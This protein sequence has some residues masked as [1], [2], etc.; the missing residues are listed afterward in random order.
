MFKLILSTRKFCRKIKNMSNFRYT[1]ST[2][3][4]CDWAYRMFEQWVDERNNAVK[5]DSTQVQIV[6]KLIDMPN[7][8]IVY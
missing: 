7:W 5:H 2:A 4:K 3:K 1:D 8:E 6:R